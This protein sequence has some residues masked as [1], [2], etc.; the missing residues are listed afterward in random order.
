MDDSGVY[1]RAQ[2]LAM[3][4]DDELIRRAVQSGVLVRLRVGWYAP[5]RRPSVPRPLDSSRPSWTPSAPD[6]SSD[7]K[8]PRMPSTRRPP[9]NGERGRRP[10]SSRPQ[11]CD[12]I[13][14]LR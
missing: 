4:Y 3:G 12:S 7:R 5:R 1:T 2:L 8:A 6:A 11:S 9:K 14:R 10:D 13:S